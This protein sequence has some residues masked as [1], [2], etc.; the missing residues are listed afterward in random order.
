MSILIRY[1]DAS[2]YAFVSLY[3]HS[4][5]DITYY[6]NAYK[7]IAAAAPVEIQSLN[8]LPYPLPNINTWY[9]L[10]V[11]MRANGRL[12]LEL[13]ELTTGSI[14]VSTST[15]YG[16]IDTA[17]SWMPV[18]ATLNGG[19]LA[20]G[21]IGLVDYNSSTTAI[22]RYYGEVRVTSA[23]DQGTIDITYR[24]SSR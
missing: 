15:V 4:G 9:I 12:N 23:I 19:T 14:V 24:N 18:D 13:R 17:T 22:T 5:G 16:D 6:I 11:T 3:R 2:N 1:V 10:S 20:T 8:V 7:V 21:K